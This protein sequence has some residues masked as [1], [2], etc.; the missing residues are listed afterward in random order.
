M[1]KYLSILIAV[2]ITQFLFSADE[3][4]EFPD[5]VKGKQEAIEKIEIHKKI[6]K[7]AMHR[8]KIQHQP[9]HQREIQLRDEAMENLD[10]AIERKKKDEK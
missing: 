9:K 10:S 3:G 2:L 5:Y 4:H 8:T 7:E 1:K 6:E